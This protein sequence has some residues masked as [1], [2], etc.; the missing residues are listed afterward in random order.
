M[1]RFHLLLGVTTPHPMTKHAQSTDPMGIPIDTSW[2][3]HNKQWWNQPDIPTLQFQE[4]KHTRSSR[5][6]ALHLFFAEHQNGHLFVQLWV[7]KVASLKLRA[8]LLQA[9]C[10]LQRSLEFPAFL[11]TEFHPAPPTLPWLTRTDSWGSE[12]STSAESFSSP[13]DSSNFSQHP[14]P[15]IEASPEHIHTKWEHHPTPSPALSSAS[16]LPVAR[17]SSITAH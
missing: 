17:T 1:D 8:D 5:A 10:R 16:I 15:W 3:S 13:P 4:K 2:I 7:Q 12:T 6:Q 14:H 9:N 11:T